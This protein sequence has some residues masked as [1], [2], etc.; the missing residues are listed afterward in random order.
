MDPRLNPFVP[1]AGTEPAE[2]TGRTDILDQADIALARAKRGLHAKSFIAV[3]LRGVGKTVILNRVALL[4]ERQGFRSVEIEA[5]ED[6]R[7]AALIVPELRKAI[8]RLTP[9]ASLGQK[10]RRA[11]QAL[12]GF[13]SAVRMTIGEFDISIDLDAEPGLADSGDLDTDLA[14][15]MVTVGEAARDHEAGILLTIDEIQYLSDADLGS[16]IRAMHK[17]AQKRIP[18][19]LAAAGLPSIVGLSGDAKSYAERLFDFPKVGALDENDT[20][21]ALTAPAEREGVKFTDSALQAIYAS[22]RGYPYF[23][24][25]WGYQS[26]NAAAGPIIDLPDIRIAEAAALRRLDEGFFRVRLDRLT[27]SER[28][29]LRAMAELGPGPHRS[30]DIA[31]RTNRTTT[32]AGALRDGLIRKGMIWSPAYGD[33][34]FTVPLFDDFMKREAPIWSPTPRRSRPR[35]KA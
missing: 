14:D 26:W 19:V 12:K 4:G 6:R 1:S 17:V 23:V 20:R 32:D 13:M 22:T 8:L 3:G 34:A 16:L 2:L 11:L 30:R 21:Y 28:E 29:Y 24:Q 27:P 9:L 10:S 33:T 7:L 31:K 15:L 35:R 18:V 5:R 25:E